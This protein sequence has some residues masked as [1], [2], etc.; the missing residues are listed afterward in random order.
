MKVARIPKL[1][2]PL[3]TTNYRFYVFY[4]GRGGGKSENIA[5][6]LVLMAVRSKI[7]ILCIRENQTSLAESVKSL[8]EK[9]IN[10]LDLYKKFHI[11]GSSIRCNNGSEFIFMGMRNSNAVNVK[12]ISNINITW[13]EEAEAFSKR[14]WDLLVPSVIRTENPKIIVSFNPNREDDIVY[15]EFIGNTPPANSYIR[16]VN[17]EE[18]PF[19]KDSVLELQRQDDEL[20]LPYEEYAHR[21]LGELVKHNEDSLFK[22]CDFT[23]LDEPFNPSNYTKM[24][25][26]CDPATTDKDH[27]N[28]YGIVVLGKR[29]DGLIDVVDDYSG[30]MTPLEFALNVCKAKEQY[31]VNNVVVEVNNGGDFIKATLIQMDPTLNV[32]EVRAGTDKVQRALPV[33]NLMSIK[34]LRL[35]YDLKKL[36]RQMRLLT[37]KGFMGSKGESPDRLDACVWGVYYLADIKTRDSIN[38][39]FNPEHFNQ[40]E[41]YLRKS[42]V[43]KENTTYSALI[44]DKFYCIS[45]DTL[46]NVLDYRLFIKNAF[47]MDFNDFEHFCHSHAHQVFLRDTGSVRNF[48]EN[49]PVITYESLKEKKTDNLVLNVIP[50]IKASKVYFDKNM[51][52]STMDTRYGQ[53]LFIDLME[54]KWDSETNYPFVELLCDIIYNEFD[55]NKDK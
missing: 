1:Y 47:V 5:Q 20:R 27:S 42:I 28:E 51:P 2:E 14:S 15:K 10:E 30:N 52:E 13:V 32:I 54:Y 4:G 17:F 29:K 19:F 9:W 38:T 48:G 39:V 40:D 26:G 31:G 46:K 18:N 25:V 37:V 8:I 50:F 22:N 16:K 35:L 44:G 45:F 11:T 6:T 49:L 41:D 24:V 43:M 23:P 55:L 36:V 53:L 34:K 33:A 7:R 12:S 3:F 21:W